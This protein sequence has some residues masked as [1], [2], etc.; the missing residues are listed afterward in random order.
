MSTHYPLVYRH[1]VE[2]GREPRK[3]KKRKR[4]TAL[5]ERETP[6]APVAPRPEFSFWRAVAHVIVAVGVV[7]VLGLGLAQFA[8]KTTEG[9]K[10]LGRA[11]S[12]LCRLVAVYTFGLSWLL[13]TKRRRGAVV[14]SGAWV[15]VVFVVW[16]TR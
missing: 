11:V 5:V 9:A 13:Q 12:A 15:L 10:H 8:T 4:K 2:T 3:E 7:L 6:A 14:Y 16:W 1:G